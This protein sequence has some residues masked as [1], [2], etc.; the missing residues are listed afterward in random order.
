MRTTFLRLL[1]GAISRDSGVGATLHSQIL[2]CMNKSHFVG[3]RPTTDTATALTSTRMTMVAW[4]SAG[5]TALEEEKGKRRR[6]T[7]TGSSTSRT[8]PRGSDLDDMICVVLTL[9]AVLNV[10]K[11]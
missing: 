4:K 11:M 3:C 1:K 6:T 2:M 7:R 9:Y 5:A 8:P 10:P